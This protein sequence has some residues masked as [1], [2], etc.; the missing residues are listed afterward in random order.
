MSNHFLI[1]IGFLFTMQSYICLRKQP[2]KK[3]CYLSPFA[4]FWRESSQIV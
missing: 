4:H 1:V 3:T 2:R